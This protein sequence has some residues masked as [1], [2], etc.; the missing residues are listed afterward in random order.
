[1]SQYNNSS[2]PTTIKNSFHH[3]YYWH[4]AAQGAVLSGPSYSGNINQYREIIEAENWEND[5]RSTEDW[6]KGYTIN[7]KTYKLNEFQ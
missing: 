1:M 2:K 7:D 6:M 4:G 3:W 5:T